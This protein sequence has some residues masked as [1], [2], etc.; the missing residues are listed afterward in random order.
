MLFRRQIIKFDS[1]IFISHPL[2]F[3]LA[4]CVPTYTQSAKGLITGPVR[5]EFNYANYPRSRRDEAREH[6]IFQ[7]DPV[8]GAR[9]EPT[10]VLVCVYVFVCARMNESIRSHQTS[11]HNT[12][13]QRAQLCME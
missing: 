1:K 2:Q 4:G 3:G 10:F 7:G 12:R 6:M 13:I 9:P 11:L 8:S 5:R